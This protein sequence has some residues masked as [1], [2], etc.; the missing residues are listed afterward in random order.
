[1]SVKPTQSA[2]RVL[3]VLEAIADQQPVGVSALA[4]LLG[5]DK[6]AVQRAIVTLA[7]AG[8]ISAAPGPTKRWELTAHIFVVAY[9]SHGKNDLRQRAKTELDALRN[10]TDETALLVMPDI[11]HFVV[12]DVVESRQ[13]LRT[14][15][16]IGTIALARESATGLAVLPFLSTE[17]RIEMLGAAPDK[18]LLD[19]FER[20][21]RDGYAVATDLRHGVTSIVA[22]I[23]E[24]DGSPV[25]AVTVTAPTERLGPEKYTKIGALVLRAAHNLSRGR[26]AGAGVE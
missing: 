4:R 6:N 10:E 23:F 22:P 7:Q 8:W 21:L 25:A 5:D 15:P 24:A 18:D 19:K 9:K 13:L 2:G 17:R 12:A 14:A 1:V 26:P 11:R 16:D 3:A 20:T